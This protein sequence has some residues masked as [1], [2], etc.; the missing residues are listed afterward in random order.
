MIRA[1]VLT[2][3][4][5]Y[6]PKPSLPSP[7]AYE[8]PS[9]PANRDLGPPPPGYGRYA[10]YD[11]SNAGGG[12][13]GGGQVGMPGNAGPPLGPRRNLDDVMCF[14]VWVFIYSFSQGLLMQS[15]SSQCGEKGH[16]ANH[17]R[18]RNV[19]GNRGGVD[20]SRRYGGTGED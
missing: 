4:I 6:S 14:K 15:S 5:K 10:D 18:N 19:P 17:C 7:S 16:Y 11:R 2:L 12:G 13:G 3:L 1:R 9:P 20:R 8:P